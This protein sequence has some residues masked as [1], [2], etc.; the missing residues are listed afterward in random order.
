[1][2]SVAYGTQTIV[3][4]V[5]RKSLL[6]N[7]Y[8]EVDTQGVHVK[9]NELTTPEEIDKMVR[10]KSAWIAKKIER[11]KCIA[12]NKEVCTGSRLYYMGKSYYVEMKSDENAN[13]IEVVFTH[14]KFCIC[15]PPQYTNVELHNA[16]EDF[17]KQKAQ[18]KIVP[19]TKK[20][21]KR[22]NVSPEHVG[23]RYAK[24]R[25]G[26]CSPTHRLT[27]NYHLVKLSS[28]LVEYVVIHE[29]AHIRH[30]NHSK[31]FWKLVHTHLAD[32]K[33]KEEKIEVFE[34]LF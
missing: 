29:L 3:F 34:R 23:F 12:I 15:T 13:G 24:N 26:S 16:I 22:M 4:E 9:T 28:S 7:T 18:E 1:M 27:F 20:W 17:Y 5:E 33:T 10:A 30:P 6:K 19:L 31:A 14:S 21:A 32:Y 2:Y 11:F 25:W 8:I